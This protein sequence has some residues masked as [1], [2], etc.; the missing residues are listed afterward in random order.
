MQGLLQEI[1]HLLSTNYELN[2]RIMKEGKRPISIL[3]NADVNALCLHFWEVF[4]LWDGLFLLAQT[5]GLMEQD[6][7]TYLRYVLAVVHGNDALGCTVTPKVHTMLKHIPF[8]MRYIWGGLGDQKEDWVEQLH[9]TGM[10]LQQHFCMVQNPVIQVLAREK[11]NSHL[12]HPDVIAHTNATNAGN[13]RSFSVV[14]VGDAISTRQ[15]RQR[16]MGRYEAMKYF[17]KDVNKNL[18]WSVIFDDVKA[19][20][21]G[22]GGVRHQLGN[23]MILY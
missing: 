21:G 8:Q 17:D 12:S 9:Q 6:T 4:V 7:K 18:T 20:G 15:K 11:V 13:K 14:K 22:G 2:L 10:R 3:S 16:D 5:V 1:N 23:A 19:G